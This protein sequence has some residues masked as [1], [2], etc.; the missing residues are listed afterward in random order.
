MYISVKVTLDTPE[1]YIEVAEIRIIK[2]YTSA[3]DGCYLSA[4]R[5]G[6]ITPLTVAEKRVTGTHRIEG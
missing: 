3:P 6:R 2:L 5:F 1:L 4:S